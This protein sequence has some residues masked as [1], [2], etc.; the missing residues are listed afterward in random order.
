M[1]VA[2]CGN[3][4]LEQI[5]DILEARTVDEYDLGNVR[6]TTHRSGATSTCR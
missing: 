3:V 5:F 1:R 6:R 2:S 4:N